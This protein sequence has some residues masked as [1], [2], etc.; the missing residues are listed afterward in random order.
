MNAA[1]ALARSK[2]L[3]AA[4]YERT[5]ERV[6]YANGFKPRPFQTR[7]GEAQFQ[8]P[9]IRGIAFYP[10]FLE[11]WQRSEQA[12]KVAIAEMYLSGVSTRS[13]TVVQTE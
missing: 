10:G 4:P 6:G 12:L 3:G 8:I 1:M 13:W 7:M 11:K 2:A 5:E 9:Q